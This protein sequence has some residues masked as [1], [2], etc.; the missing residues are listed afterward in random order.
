MLSAVIWDFTACFGCQ[1]TGKN[2]E[3]STSIHRN[4]LAV[5]CSAKPPLNTA[6]KYKWKWCRLTSLC[7]PPAGP[8]GWTVSSLT[9]E[10]QSIIGGRNGLKEHSC[11]VKD[12]RFYLFAAEHI[13]PY[14]ELIKKVFLVLPPITGLMGKPVTEKD[15]LVYQSECA[16]FWIWGWEQR[17]GILSSLCSTE[18]LTRTPGDFWPTHTHTHTARTAFN[19]DKCILAANKV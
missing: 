12:S 13:I 17:S 19:E 16:L 18:A 6:N 9:S 11:A 15:S 4:H 8:R 10:T 2:T 7:C 3:G 1:I 5:L 14:S